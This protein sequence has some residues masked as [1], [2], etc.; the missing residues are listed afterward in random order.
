MPAIKTGP[1]LYI[2]LETLDTFLNS[3]TVD[4]RPR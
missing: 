3:R 4:K 1:F 2:R